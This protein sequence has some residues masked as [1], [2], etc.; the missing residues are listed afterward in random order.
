MLPMANPPEFVIKF[1]IGSSFLL[2]AWAL[3][4]LLLNI[5]ETWPIFVCIIASWLVGH[6]ALSWYKKEKSKELGIETEE[7]KAKYEEIKKFA[8][9]Y[10][11]KQKD[12]V[13]K[14]QRARET[15]PPFQDHPYLKHTSYNQQNTVSP[16]PDYMP[17]VLGVAA[18]YVAGTQS[19]SSGSQDTCSSSSDS[20][21]SSCGS[22]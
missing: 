20:S 2:F 4:S 8:E 1:A 3:G 12:D 5:E 6:V 22:E 17:V 9:A 13:Y 16:G 19:N 10:A 14:Y 15:R 21:S 7:E 18:G 11:E